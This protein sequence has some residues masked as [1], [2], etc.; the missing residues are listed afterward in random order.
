M[1]NKQKAEGTSVRDQVKK[2]IGDKTLYAEGEVK[3][4]LIIRTGEAKKIE[5]P[6]RVDLSGIISAPAKFYEKRKDLH[7]KNKCHVVFD[8]Q[9][10]FLKLVV[11]EQNGESGYSVSGKL[12]PNP[13]LQPFRLNVDGTS[14][15]K[16]HVK[17]LMEK[18]KFNKYFFVDKDLNAQIVT[19][20]MKFKVR[21]AQEIESINNQRGD[22]RELKATTLSHELKEF[23]MLRM[24]IYKGLSAV[25]FRVEILCE[26]S[27][28]GEVLVWLES[29]ELSEINKQTLETVIGAELDIFKEI[30]C[31]EQ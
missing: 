30:V 10:G 6:K 13:H 7:D 24:P 28:S 5:Y 31:I 3:N 17:D 14:A 20:L 12:T 25:D 18:L 21:V 2:F 19:S 26:V 29:S 4:E 16:F 23:F 15:G 1:E 8:K 9:S 27:S 11:D 22:Q